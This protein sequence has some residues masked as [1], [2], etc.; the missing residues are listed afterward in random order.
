MPP[1][2][3]TMGPIM[4]HS[5]PTAA[6]SPSCIAVPFTDASSPP[7]GTTYYAPPVTGIVP[8]HGVVTEEGQG[9]PSPTDTCIPY[10]CY[11]Y[12]PYSV[13]PPPPGALPL[14][15]TE[16][17]AASSAGSSPAPHC[18]D[19]VQQ[20]PV[21]QDQQMTGVPIAVPTTT[22]TG[23]PVGPMT[24]QEAQYQQTTVDGGLYH[25]VMPP[26]QMLHIQIP[27]QQRQ[28]QVTPAAYQPTD[29]NLS[30]PVPAC[31]HSSVTTKYVHS[32]IREIL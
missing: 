8:G 22:T 30:V 3:Q 13:G 26:T 4:Q 11:Q 24:V 6:G 18:Q 27:L 28:P 14:V 31:Q 25:T 29:S 23:Y 1:T 12:I 15:F 10:S 7:T 32:I 20:S 16:P 2:L 17:N 9:A 5:Y 19:I 21:S